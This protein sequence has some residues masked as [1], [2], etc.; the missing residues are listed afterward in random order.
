[1]LPSHLPGRAFEKTDWIFNR[2]FTSGIRTMQ[3][4]R[5]TQTQFPFAELTFRRIDGPRQAIAAERAAVSAF[6]P[7]Q[8]VH[9]RALETLADSVLWLR[10]RAARGGYWLATRALPVADQW[11]RTVGAHLAA[12][13]RAVVSYVGAATANPSWRRFV[14]Q[15]GF[16]L[17]TRARFTAVLGLAFVAGLTAA[18]LTRAHSTSA[19]GTDTAPMRPAYPEVAVAPLVTGSGTAGAWRQG[20]QTGA[21]GLRAPD[22][23][24]GEPTT[25]TLFLPPLDLPPSGLIPAQQPQASRLP[26]ANGATPPASPAARPSVPV[27]F[28]PAPRAPRPTAATDLAPR[29]VFAVQLAAGRTQTDLMRLW[30][31]LQRQ[32]GALLA[33]RSPMLV[34]RTTAGDLV[35]LRVGGFVAKPEADA[36]C[37]ALKK[38]KTQCFVVAEKS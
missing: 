34:D 25:S 10:N 28:A 9:R 14:R 38:Q 4:T 33:D 20:A 18:L 31:D 27:V 1:M 13:T 11:A 26:R 8:D 19:V 5:H 35:R 29:G 17:G 24:S 15:D 36:L 7:W 12:A 2:V 6:G 23:V 22:G 37:A 30:Q 3:G 16:P 32:H 21:S